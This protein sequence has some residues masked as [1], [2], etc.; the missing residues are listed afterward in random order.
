MGSKGGS[1]EP[2]TSVVQPT[3]PA[4]PNQALLNGL[5]Q[6]RA[7]ATIPYTSSPWRAMD[8]FAQY[9]TPTQYMPQFQPPQGQQQQAPAAGAGQAAGAGSG[10]RGSEGMGSSVQGYAPQQQQQPQ[11]PPMQLQ[12]NWWQT[13][14][15][16]APTAQGMQGMQQNVSPSLAGLFQLLNGQ[17]PNFLGSGGPPPGQVPDTNAVMQRPPMQGVPGAGGVDSSVNLTNL[18]QTGAK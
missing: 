8:Y 10:A 1:S 18:P 5:A 7:Q 2:T 13:A 12:N 15:M 9:Q 17:T 6:S 14:Q 11:T 16:S 4:I 3:L